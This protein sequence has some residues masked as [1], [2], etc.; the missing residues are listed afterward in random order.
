MGYLSSLYIF[1][2]KIFNYIFDFLFHFLPPS[3]PTVWLRCTLS[4]FGIRRHRP[5]LLKYSVLY[6]CGDLGPSPSLCKRDSRRSSLC[7]DC[8]GTERYDKKTGGLCKTTKIGTSNLIKQFRRCPLLRRWGVPTT[9]LF[10][11]IAHYVQI[12]IMDHSLVFTLGDT[13]T[14]D[15]NSNIIYSW[16]IYS[17]GARVERSELR[18]LGADRGTCLGSS[19]VRVWWR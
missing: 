11:F 7:R 17:D 13:F 19:D 16:N 1:N 2:L 5:K 14:G 18:T 12:R 3:S 4:E 10:D 8:F 6:V 9:L 15:D